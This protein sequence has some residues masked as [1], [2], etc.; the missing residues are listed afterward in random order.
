MRRE[1]NQPTYNIFDNKNNHFATENSNSP[2]INALQK[3]TPTEMPLRLNQIVR[4]FD[5]F[6]LSYPSITT[7]SQSA[8]ICQTNS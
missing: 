8:M 2:F 6:L 3:R 5:R 1:V 4:S 7:L